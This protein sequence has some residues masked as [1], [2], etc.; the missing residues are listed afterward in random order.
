MKRR[1]PNT[2]YNPVSLVGSAIAFVSLGTVLFLFFVELVSEQTKPYVGILTYIVLPA[3]MIFGLFLIPIGMWI[4]RRRRR[5]SGDKGM[6]RF[7]RIDLNE[8]RQR[9]LFAFFS[10]STIFLL[11][12]TAIGSYRAYEFTDSV[13][14]CGEICHNVMRPE[15][16]AYHNSAHARVTCAEC[17]VGPGATWFVRSKLSGAYQVYAVAFNLY[18]RP[19]P[20]PVRSLRPAQETC[21]QCHWP[22]YFYGKKEKV[23]TYFLSDEKNTKWSVTLLLKTGGGTS[24]TGPTSGIHWHMNIANEITYVAT[25]SSRQKIAWVRSKSMDGKVTEYMSVDDPLSPEELAK[26]EKRRMDCMDCHNRPTH[27]YHSPAQIINQALELGRIDATLPSIRS[28]AVQ[29][30][31]QPYSSTAAASDSIGIFIRNFYQEGYPEIAQSKRTAIDSAVVE[32]KSGYQ[33]NFFPE[34]RV[35][36]KAYPNNIGHLQDLGCFRCHDGNHASSDGKTISHD[37]NSCHT[38]IAQGG[39]EVKETSSLDGL[40]FQH[41]IDIGD[42]WKT[43]SC[44]E[45]HTGE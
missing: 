19:I 41:P 22:Q 26:A 21:E 11:L 6:P 10:I 20:T 5:R 31:V 1:L 4:E 3:F 8:P 9:S 29:A 33:K 40:A 30:L 24:A 35:S 42:A 28:T 12:F 45:C 13:T 34:M 2:F 39:D 7:P 37:C 16:T 15:F 43:T 44:N 23:N 14:F 25:D 32:V 38:I 17:H 27:V 18:P 36:W